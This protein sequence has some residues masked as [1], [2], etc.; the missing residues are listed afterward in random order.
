MNGAPT[1]GRGLRWE[2]LRSDEIRAMVARGDEWFVLLPIGAVEQ[3]GDHLPVDVDIHCAQG[4]CDG[5]AARDDHVVVAPPISWGFSAAQT[6]R[7]GTITLKGETLLALLRDVLDSIYATGFRHVM[8]VNGHN[9]NKWMAGQAVSEIAR[10]PGTTLS[11]LTYF[12]LTLD[13]F[14]EHRVSGV[15]G[16]GHGGE[17]ETAMELFL[18]PDAVRDDRAVRY[19]ASITDHGMRDLAVRGAL[20]GIAGPEPMSDIY[21]DGIMGDPTVATAELGGRLFGAAVGGIEEIIA[22]VR[23]SVGATTEHH[24]A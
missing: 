10:P 13:V 11:A 16:E 1:A 22:D 4:V 23:T 9:G 5:V 15:G 20:L 8:V 2:D 18:R 24:G 12:D 3:H 6:F 14:R 19:V 21:P 17:L 7:P